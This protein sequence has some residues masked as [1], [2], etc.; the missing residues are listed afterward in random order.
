MVKVKNIS[1]SD[2]LESLINT[3]CIKHGFKLYI[4]GWTR[5][6]FDVFKEE[7]RINKLDHLARIESLAVTNG[8]IRIFDDQAGEFVQELGEAIEEAFDLE[9]AIVIREKRPE[10]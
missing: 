10:Y 1:D 9:E 2:K 8:E 7:R 6:T 4:E 5:K 3:T